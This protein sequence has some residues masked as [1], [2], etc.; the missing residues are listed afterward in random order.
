LPVGLVVKFRPSKLL[1]LVRAPV[2]LSLRVN[3][4][5]SVMFWEILSEAEMM[6]GGGSVLPSLES[7]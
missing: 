5:S 2:G 1:R 6:A 4:L 3:G 7:R